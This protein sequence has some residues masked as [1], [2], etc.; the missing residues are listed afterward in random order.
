MKKQQPKTLLIELLLASIKSAKEKSNK[1]E[2][3]LDMLGDT[4]FDPSKL[5][6]MLQNQ[7]VAD[8]W[9]KD[10]IDDGVLDELDLEKIENSVIYRISISKELSEEK[11]RQVLDDLITRIRLDPK[12]WKDVRIRLDK[13]WEEKL[14]I[15]IDPDWKNKL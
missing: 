5:E 1:Q 9:I 2:P 11:K 12:D 3:L 10:L 8:E 7:D 6:K 15:R 4:K 13:D 14:D